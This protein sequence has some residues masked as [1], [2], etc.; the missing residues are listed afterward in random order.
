MAMIESIA[1]RT[2]ARMIGSAS[3]SSTRHSRCT[4]G[5]PHAARRLHNRRIDAGQ[6]DDHVPYQHQLRIRDQSNHC[7]AQP[8]ASER[9]EKDKSDRLGIV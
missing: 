5:H 3:G 8:Q 2:P 4:A 6:P 9:D 7:R 1:T